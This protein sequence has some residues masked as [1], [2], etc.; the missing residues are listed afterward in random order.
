[1]TELLGIRSSIQDVALVFQLPD[2]QNSVIL[3]RLVPSQWLLNLVQDVNCR[4]NIPVVV[5]TA[6]RTRPFAD[7]QRF[8]PA[9]KATVR[10]DLTGVVRLHYN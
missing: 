6:L 8:F 4:I 9:V 1:M 2:L 10:T 5:N 7:F 3:P